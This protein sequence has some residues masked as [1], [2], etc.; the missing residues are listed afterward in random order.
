MRWRFRSRGELPLGIA[1]EEDLLRVV[2]MQRQGQEYQVKTFSF[3]L[4]DKTMP[5]DP[6]SNQ[7]ALVELLQTIRKE[8][9]WGQRSVVTALPSTQVLVR[10]LQ[11]PAMAATE[12]EKAVYWEAKQ[13]LRTDL[14]DYSFD[15]MILSRDLSQKDRPSLAI[16]L[17]A[18]PKEK[19]IGIYQL[20]SKAGF[21]LKAID[22]VPLAL[23]RALLSGNISGQENESTVLLDLGSNCTQLA[24]VSQGQLTFSRSLPFCIPSGARKDGEDANQSLWSKT[25]ELLTEMRRSLDYFQAQTRQKA[26]ELI[27]SGSGS[28]WPGFKPLLQELNLKVA[29]GIPGRGLELDQYPDPSFAVALGLALKGVRE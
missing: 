23:K 8:N 7:G 22:V 11:V 16:M 15:Y 20:F 27:I 29:Y 17:A 5:D 19:A 25:K 21:Q 4:P 26:E 6:V 14:T 9:R 3:P 10:H 24:I 1:W 2:D 18:I 12:V 13:L 28:K